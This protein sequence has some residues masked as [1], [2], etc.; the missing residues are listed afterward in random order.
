MDCPQRRKMGGS[1]SPIWPTPDGIQLFLPLA[2]RRDAG[3]DFRGFARGGRSFR[4]KHRLNS[5]KSICTSKPWAK[6]AIRAARES[7]CIGTTRGGK[8]TK[9]HSL[10]NRIGLPVQLAITAGNVQDCS[11][12]IPLVEQSPLK[13]GSNLLGDRIYGSREFRNYLTGRKILYT[14]PPKKNIKN[15][16]PYDKAGY[17]RR[18]IVERFFCRIKDFRRIATRY[19][20]R[21]D[22]FFAFVL[23]AA[24]FVSFAILHI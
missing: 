8:T 3:E 22:S 6:K 4:N 5:R 13:T 17:K 20:K 11:E 1:T 14:I 16:W 12:A 21:D 10:V 19:D 9:I 2:G 7:F 23:L 15:P 18:N 24:S